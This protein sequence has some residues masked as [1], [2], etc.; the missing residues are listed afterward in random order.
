MKTYRKRKV[1]TNS[2]AIAMKWLRGPLGSLLKKRTGRGRGIFSDSEVVC[3]IPV[4]FRFCLPK[5]PGRNPNL[6]FMLSM[7]GGR[8]GQMRLPESTLYFRFWQSRLVAMYPIQAVT[9][10]ANPNPSKDTRIV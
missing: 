5:S 10:R 9:E 7:S 6:A 4:P 8:W 2:P 3:E 1:P